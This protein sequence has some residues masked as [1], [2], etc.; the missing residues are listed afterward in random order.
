MDFLKLAGLLSFII[1]AVHIAIIFGGPRW[2]RFFGAGEGM[3]Q[4]AEQ[5]LL[6]P[7]LITVSISMVLAVWG[8]Y[9]WS[10]AGLIPKLP[11]L[12]TIISGITAVYLVR[13]CGGLIAPFVS[14]HP[15]ILQN[16]IGF[17]V[18]SSII[19]ILFGVVHLKGVIEKWAVL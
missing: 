19:C 4:M 18:W 7:T 6:R 3:V 12:K 15:L 16:S 8:A 13:G 10:G 9:A 5:N 11:F 14:S 2:Y 17:W 1:S